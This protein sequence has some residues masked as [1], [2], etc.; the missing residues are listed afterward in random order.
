MNPGYAGRMELPE[1][2]KNLFRTVSMVVPDYALIGEIMLYAEGMLKANTLSKKII[3]LFKMFHEQ[4]S[5]QHHYDFGMRAVKSVFK[6]SGELLKEKP[7]LDE[8]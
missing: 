3:S 7:N 6:F 8:E 5:T 2:L 4:F 1:N